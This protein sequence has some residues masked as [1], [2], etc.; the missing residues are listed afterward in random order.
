M[1]HVPR[2]WI[3]NVHYHII[4]RSNRKDALFKNEADYEFFIFLLEE[5]SKKHPFKIASYI[6]MRTHFHLLLHSE[7]IDYSQIMY[8]IKKKYATY[9]NKKYNQ[10]G[11]LFDK[12]YSAKPATST[13]TLLFM[14]RYIHYNPVEI[15]LVKRPEDYRWSSFPVLLK[16]DGTNQ[17]PDYINFNPLF[18]QF[19]G[20]IEE[21]KREYVYWC[22]FH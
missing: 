14:S 8:H 11:H 12:R 17:L 19:R 5:T 18:Q 15:N 22:K 10:R 1:P 4:S 13:R 16:T 7:T 20:N 21:R 9:F 2:N 6:L 3:P